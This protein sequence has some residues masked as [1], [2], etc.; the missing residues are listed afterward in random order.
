MRSTKVKLV[1]SGGR[2]CLPL[3]ARQV[4]QLGRTVWCTAKDGTLH[5]TSAPPVAVLP[6][7]MDLASFRPQPGGA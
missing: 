6:V 3:T 7:V 1:R 2:L 5:V 4:S